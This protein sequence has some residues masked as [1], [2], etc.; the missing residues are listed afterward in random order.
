MRSSIGGCVENERAQKPVFFRS[1]LLI[2]K[3]LVALFAMRS[4]GFGSPEIFLKAPA[5]PSGYRVSTAA[6]ASA[7]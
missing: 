1:G 6:P 7:A 5:S 2:N 3:W 4:V